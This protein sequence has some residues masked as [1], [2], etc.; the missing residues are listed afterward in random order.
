MSI[1]IYYIYYLSNLSSFN[2][3]KFYLFGAFRSHISLFR[4]ILGKKYDI[5]C[6]FRIII[7]IILL[8][9]LACV[10]NLI[11]IQVFLMFAIDL[12]FLAILNFKKL[13]LVINS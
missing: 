13:H 11:V 8:S 1:Y 9:F 4:T 5:L 12:R 10:K 2:V 7:L 3:T 6:L